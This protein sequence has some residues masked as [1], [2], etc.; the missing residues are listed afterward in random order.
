VSEESPE[1]RED[2]EI[3]RL[4]DEMAEGS[5]RDPYELLSGIGPESGDLRRAYVETLAQL[6]YELEGVSPSPDLRTRLLAEI[7]TSESVGSGSIA[8]HGERQPVVSLPRWLLPLAA[9]VAFVLVG[10]TGWQ[11][12]RVEQQAETIARLS[13]EL[14]QSRLATAELAAARELVDE[15]RARMELMTASTAEFCALKPTVSCPNQ[16]ARGTI[17][18]QRGQS[19]WF[20]RVEGL[21][22]CEKGRQYKLWF[23]TDSKPI[24]GASFSVE[25]SH[26]LVEIRATGAPEGVKA[27]MITLE[28]PEV[29]A[30][31]E[32]PVLLFGDQTMRIL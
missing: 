16:E 25:G 29:E 3:L 26:E 1:I 14:E 9:T 31:P 22:P 18:M 28:Q 27:V 32:A 17:V 11:V 30:A 8:E 6:P 4:L 5:G 13:A 19:D 20:L 21:G 10:V 2:E 24:L 7:E 23:V 12:W 15:T